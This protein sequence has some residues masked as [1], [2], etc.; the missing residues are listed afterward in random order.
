[1]TYEFAANLSLMFTERPMLERPA[2]ARA[3]G[4]ETVEAWWPF[5]EPV[6][7]DAEARRFIDALDE[8]GVRLIGLNFFA[9]DMPGGERGVACRPG[10]QSELAANTEQLI[11]IAEATGCRSFNLLYGQLDDRWS[12]QEQHDTALRAVR[13]AAERVLA[14]DGTV[15]L[16]PLASPLNGNYPLTTGDQVVELLE[17]PLA[18][19]PNVGLLFDLFHLRANGIDL[20]PAASAWA[21]WIKHVQIADFPGR[22]EP[23]SGDSPIR[24]TLA[25][26][27]EVGYDG[28]IACEYKPTTTTEQTLGW[29]TD[30]S[31]DNNREDRG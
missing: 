22:G 4:F 26:L 12:E 13:S 10:R 29:L 6:V 16:E 1:M 3:A 25:A 2:A 27:D 24:E 9:G 23:G 19:L 30:Y 20:V 21:R 11:M 31:I 8:A 28:S 14:V 17:G 5:A 18:D 7:D 15:L